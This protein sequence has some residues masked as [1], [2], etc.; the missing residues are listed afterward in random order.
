MKQE[1]I[2]GKF[3]IYDDDE[4]AMWIET[5]RPVNLKKSR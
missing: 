1:V 2:D 3:V 5:P 4:R